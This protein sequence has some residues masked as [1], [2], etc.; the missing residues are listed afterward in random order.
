MDFVKI[1]T[2]IRK[3]LKI[4]FN[5]DTTYQNLWKAVKPVLKIKCIAIDVIL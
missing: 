3:Y 4:N 5:K 2:E 1:I